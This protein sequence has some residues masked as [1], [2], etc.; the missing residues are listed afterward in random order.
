[1]RW[2]RWEFLPMRIANFPVFLYYVFQ[3]IRSLDP[4]FFSAVNPTIKTGGLF[5]NSKM[6]IYDQI[7]DSL[8]PATAVIPEEGKT[9]DE[10]VKKM[11]AMGIDF[12]IILKPDIGERGFHVS[13]VDTP[14]EI[15]EALNAIPG[16]VILQEYIDYPLEISIL[17]YQFPDSD[18]RGITSICLKEFLTVKGD[19]T[20]TI[21]ALMEQSARATLQIE[22]LDGITDLSRVP[23]QDE[24]VHLEPIGNHSRGTKFLN[25][26]HLLDDE[27][28]AFAFD[29]LRQLPGVQYG[30]FDLRAR[31]LE[32]LRRGEHFKILEFNGTNSEPVHI[33]DPSFSVSKAYST[34]WKHWSIMYSLAKAQKRRGVRSMPLADGLRTG[35]NY[36]VH[37]RK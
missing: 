17:C 16:D 26:M 11:R 7:P 1:M 25:G 28:E 15:D 31:S 4:L 14:A 34:L 23:K 36:M 3:S 18:K 29:L 6:E 9:T 5:G 8:L 24:V 21:R 12:P 27:I 19:G 20:S 22:R 30:R 32:D 35:W 37:K 33:Y 10:V 13:K 2:S